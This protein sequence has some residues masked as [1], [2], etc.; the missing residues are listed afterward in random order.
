MP[1]T[2]ANNSLSPLPEKAVRYKELQDCYKQLT[3]AL[4][5]ANCDKR[6]S[7][8]YRQLADRYS[9]GAGCGGGKCRAA[10]WRRRCC[11]FALVE[12]ECATSRR[13]LGN[14]SDDGWRRQ[15]R[16]LNRQSAMGERRST[17][18]TFHVQ[19]LQLVNDSVDWQELTSRYSH[20]VS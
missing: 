13:P 17:R 14:D 2:P 9:A 16:P 1:I 15:D 3:E 8:C 5:A 7:G 6:D 12:G 18:R 11:R 20:D 4:G 10:V 19:D